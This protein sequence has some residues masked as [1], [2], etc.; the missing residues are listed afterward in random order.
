MSSFLIILFKSSRSLL[1]LG[2]IFIHDWIADLS[3]LS[4]VAIVCL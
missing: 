3:D 1:I 2:Y 4:I